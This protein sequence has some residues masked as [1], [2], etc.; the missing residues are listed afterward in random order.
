MADFCPQSYYA[1]NPEL[2]LPQVKFPDFR[3]K[4]PNIELD[5]VYRSIVGSAQSMGLRISNDEGGDEVEV[6]DK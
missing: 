6:A 2:P 3:E 5:R 1:P 4:N